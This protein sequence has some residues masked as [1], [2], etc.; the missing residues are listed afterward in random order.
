MKRMT[1]EEL[2]D[3]KVGDFV[4]CVHKRRNFTLNNV[5][6]ISQRLYINGRKS[7]EKPRIVI[8]DVGMERRLGL[9]RVTFRKAKFVESPLWKLM[10]GR[11]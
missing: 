10:N 7:K 3:L 2:N 1:E 4:V 8:D 5:Y 6:V 9:N 11:E